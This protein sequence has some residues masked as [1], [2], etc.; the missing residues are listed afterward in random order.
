[1][2]ILITIPNLSK[3]GGITRYVISL[4][5]IFSSNHSV[6][7]LTTHEQEI[8]SQIEEE[9]KSISNKIKIIS[10]SQK[11]NFFKYFDTFIKITKFNPD[12]LINN[13]NGL[14]QFLLPFLSRKIKILHVLHN[15]TND[16]YRI[17]AIN[18]NK[19]NL[20]IAPTA[21]IGNCFNKYTANKYIEKIKI[22]SHGVELPNVKSKKNIG[23]IHIIFAGVLYEH[24]GV[25]EL[26]IV[27]KSLLQKRYNIHFTIIGGGILEDWLKTEFDE[28]IKNEIVE[29]T[30]IINHEAVYNYMSQADIFY[31]PTHLDAFGLVIAEAMIN[32]AVPVVT[33]LKGV[34]DNLIDNGFNGFLLNKGDTNSFIETIEKLI[35]DRVLL[36]SISEN[37]KEVAFKRFSIATMAENYNS[38]L[39]KL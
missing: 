29:F 12:I 32:G 1:M 14:I 25:K 8:D 15:D 39:Q 27:I 11:N 33:H 18:A 19:T 10:I 21:G 22:I 30:G 26:P 28:E 38:V 37:C 36:E 5:K 20:W 35:N 4:T 2:K 31:Y 24:K 17:G 16:F 9:I 6:I 34:T 7:I 3:S 23:R 13:Y